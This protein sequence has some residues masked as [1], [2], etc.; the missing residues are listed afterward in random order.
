MTKK[1]TLK[2]VSSV[3]PKEYKAFRKILKDNKLSLS[4]YAC[5]EF[6]INEKIDNEIFDVYES[7]IKEYKRITENYLTLFDTMD[8][9]FTVETPNFES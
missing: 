5:P 6:G 7:L 1:I 4:D 8:G 2:E 3:C 9:N